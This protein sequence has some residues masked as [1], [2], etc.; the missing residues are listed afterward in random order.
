MPADQSRQGAK[1]M[2][3]TTSTGRIK[4]SISL[5]AEA[6]IH[7]EQACSRR[8]RGHYIEQL[9]KAER[10]RQLQDVL[11]QEQRLRELEA[12]IKALQ[13]RFA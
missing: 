5:D 6:F 7:L 4:I 11:L 2:P 1:I 12:K 3:N 9:I 13:E 10:Q 8:H